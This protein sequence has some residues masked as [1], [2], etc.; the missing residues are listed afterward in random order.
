MAMIKLTPDELR[1]DA[2]QYRRS[3]EMIQEMLGK[4]DGTHQNIGANWE[5]TAWQKFDQQYHE[6]SRKVRD[7]EQ[8]M[9]DI[10]KQLNDVARIVEETDATMAQQIGL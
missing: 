5:G 3:G 7:F 6:L 4:L 9:N 2:E 1:S 10:N 8:L